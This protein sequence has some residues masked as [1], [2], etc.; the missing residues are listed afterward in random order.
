MTSRI[1]IVNGDFTKSSLEQSNLEGEIVVWRELLSDGPVSEPVFSDQFWQA[2]YD[3]FEQELGVS[4]LE[5][6]DKTI[7]ELLKAEYLEEVDEVVLWFE[8]DLFCQVNLMA[9]CS[10]LLEH[11]RKD[12][13]YS[14]VCVGREK[15]RDGWQ[16]LADYAPEAF[17]SLY[18]SRI[19]MSRASF[20]Y[21]HKCW[22]VYAQKDKEA[23]QNF[24]F[25]K[26]KRFKYFHVAM[27]QEM[28]RFPDE[29]GLNQIDRKI[30]ELVSEG[31]HSLKDLV[32]LL[33]FWQ[34]AETVYGF[35]DLQYVQRLN[36]LA[37]LFNEKKGVLVLNSNGKKLLTT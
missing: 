16:T 4:R 26:N 9:L 17:A 34:K 19:N 18:E 31:N 28:E 1:H 33:L 27:Q 2:R 12:V 36:K 20:E 23:I 7:K 35:G 25:R 13:K 32:K 11:F 37:Q 14:M 5:Y 3:Y 29:N 21:A 10:F 22:N 15:G 6:F 30:V 8:Y 24:N